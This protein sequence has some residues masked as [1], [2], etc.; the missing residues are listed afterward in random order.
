[1]ESICK[2]S[3]QPLNLTGGATMARMFRVLG[4]LCGIISLLAFAGGEE[5]VALSIIFGIKTIL[6][7]VLSYM[8]LTERTYMYIFGAYMFLAFVGL[9]YWMFFQMPL[10]E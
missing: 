9:N 6:F 5:L 1:M 2:R 3:M 10:S 8:K 4:F 7:F